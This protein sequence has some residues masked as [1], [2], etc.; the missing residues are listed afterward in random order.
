MSHHCWTGSTWSTLSGPR[1]NTRG[2]MERETRKQRSRMELCARWAKRLKLIYWRRPTLIIVWGWVSLV[3]SLMINLVTTLCKLSSLMKITLKTI[4]AATLS[5]IV[6][7]YSKSEMIRRASSQSYTRLHSTMIIVPTSSSWSPCLA[8]C[9]HTADLSHSELWLIKI[10]S[11]LHFMR[12]GGIR[13]FYISTTRCLTTR[14]RSTMSGS[15]NKTLFNPNIGIK[16]C[17]TVNRWNRAE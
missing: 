15:R 6:H 11:T 3:T 5:S 2:C 8:S 14:P 16:A 10:S 4:Q 1:V 7:L 12:A 13:R 17:A 9:H